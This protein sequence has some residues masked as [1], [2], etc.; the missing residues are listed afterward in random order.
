M[1]RGA[2]SGAI[3]FKVFSVRMRDFPGA[4]RYHFGDTRATFRLSD[5]E[6]PISK[7]PAAHK[8]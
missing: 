4:C 3:F 5:K 7:S 1:S 8:D 6:N 2:A